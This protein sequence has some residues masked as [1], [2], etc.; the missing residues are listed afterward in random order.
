MKKIKK[1]SGIYRVPYEDKKDLDKE[2][3]PKLKFNYYYKKT[4]KP[5]ST[6]DLERIKKLMIP[7]SYNDVWISLNPNNKIQAT[8]IDIGGKVQYRYHIDHIQNANEKKFL[9]LYNF[10]KSMPKLNEI[11]DK[12]WK[13]DDYEKF[14]TIVVMLEIVK[15]LHIRVGKEVYAKKNKSY[16]IT[17]LKKKHVSID[18]DTIRFRFK[19]KS[20]KQLSY[21]LHNNKIANYLESLMELEGD[22]LFQYKLNDKIYRVTDVDIN[23]YIQEYMGKEF[24][25]KDF[26]TYAANYHFTKSLLN[27]TK[28]RKP[29][30]IKILK[31]NL[32]K[33]Q[34]DTAHYL[35]HTKAISK[36]S[37]VMKLLNELYLEDPEYFVKNK[38]KDPLNILMA[39]IRQ[40]KRK[41]QENRKKKD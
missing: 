1:D 5:V 30:T 21:T 31:G 24:T 34:E 25:C 17:S 29:K 6:E 28:K 22:K 12:H 10:I 4:N 15:E 19:G 33:A 27:E 36:K 14:K 16:G 9:R 3:K 41:L 26:R 37:Y 20:N 11:M 38:N 23:Q 8:G 2:G 13:L 35:R 32:K 7:P 39:I 18:E 40:F